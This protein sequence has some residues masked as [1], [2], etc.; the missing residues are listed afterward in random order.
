MLYVSGL[1]E[2]ATLRVYNLVGALVYHGIAAN[3]ET[4]C[5]APLPA[6][7]VYIVADGKTVIKVVN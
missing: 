5:I 4:Q 2:G 7:G 1:Q 3:A 6:R